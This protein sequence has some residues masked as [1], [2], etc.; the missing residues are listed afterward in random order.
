MLNDEISM[1]NDEVRIAFSDDEA[2]M[3]KDEGN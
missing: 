2:D 3:K 1:L